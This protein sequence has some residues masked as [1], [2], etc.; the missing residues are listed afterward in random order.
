MVLRLIAGM[1]QQLASP[2]AI[3]ARIAA[4]QHG[5]VTFEQLLAAGVS[6]SGI[7]RRVRAGRL[8]R[9]YRGVYAVG[10]RSLSI[11]GEWMAA[12]L[13]YKDGAALSHRSAAELWGYLKPRSG[14]IHVTLHTLSGRQKRRGI[15]LH[16]SPSVLSVTTRHN[17]IAVTTPA[18]TIADLR[19]VASV[20]EVRRAIRE[21]EFHHH[22]VSDER[23][24]E[25][26][27]TRSWL[28]RRFLRMC[29]RHNLP[30]PEVNVHVGPHEVDFL[31]RD[32][33]L[34]VETDGWEAHS[35]RQAFEDDR[36]KDA[37]LR[38]LGF[39]VLRFTHRQVTE[40]WEWVEATVRALLA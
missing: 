35:G 18:R 22:D 38:A 12:V 29:R 4:R 25:D 37:E 27:P 14:P 31:W 9:I 8:F 1:R 11:E 28:E 36:A 39:T 15:C 34:I 5:V 33:R 21:A 24:K 23:A 13:V 6:P 32:R 20:D 16:H 7:S 17:G 26:A 2:D 3:V 40:R 10:H 30:A 19:R